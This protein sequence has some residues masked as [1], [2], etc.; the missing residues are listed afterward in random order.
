MSVLIQLTSTP[1][2]M[3]TGQLHYNVRKREC[4]TTHNTEKNNTKYNH[5]KR[6]PKTIISPKMRHTKKRNSTNLLVARLLEGFDQRV[7]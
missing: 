1:S 4:T 6:E 5:T 7:D 3:T 2:S